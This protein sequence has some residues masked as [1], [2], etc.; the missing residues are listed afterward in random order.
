MTNKTNN[1]NTLS[2]R[3]SLKSLSLLTGFFFTT[4]ATSAYLSGCKADISTNWSPVS[5]SIDQLELIKQATERILPKTDTPG[6]NDALVHRYIDNAITNIYKTEDKVKFI[7]GIETF[8][9]ISREKYKKKFIELNQEKMDDV[10]KILAQEWKESKT[11]DNPIFKELRDLTVIGFATSEIGAKEFFFYDPIP[12]PYQ[13]CINY[14]D[15][16]KT[17]AL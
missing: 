5:L 14:S 10:L 11:G 1:S 8:D 7:T 9:N 13:G 16:G 17:Y 2:R 15:I 4:G 3:D 12:G 6:A